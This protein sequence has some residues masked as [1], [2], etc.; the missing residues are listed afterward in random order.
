[1]QLDMPIALRAGR[2]RI[3]CDERI[4]AV[5]EQAGIGRQVTGPAAAEQTPQRLPGALAQQ[6]PQ[7]DLDAGEGVDERPVAPEQMRAVQNGAG[8]GVDVARVAADQQRRND[9]IERGLRRGDRGVPEGFA[10]ADQTVVGLD[11]HHENVEM[12][13]GLARKQRM[14]AAHVEGKRDNKAFDRGDQHANPAKRTRIGYR[15]RF[16]KFCNPAKLNI[17]PK[18]I[19]DRVDLSAVRTSEIFWAGRSAASTCLPSQRSERR[20]K[21]GIEPGLSE[22]AR[23]PRVGP[24]GPP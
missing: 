15:R 4:I 19:G 23:A 10:P 7:R 9:G 20:V 2:R 21:V 17:S 24:F 16:F 12:V 5:P 11:L 14:R 22:M 1:M 6:I 13:P 8:E 18:T 3:P